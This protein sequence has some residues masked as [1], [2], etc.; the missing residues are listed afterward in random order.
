MASRRNFLRT[1]LAGTGA[2]LVGATKGAI[3]LSDGSNGQP[4]IMSTWDHGLPANK[5]AWEVLQGGGSVLD[6]VEQGVKVVESDFTNRSVGLGGLPDR[7]GSVTLDACIQDHEGMA[8]SV[9]FVQN[10]EN[11]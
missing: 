5:K 4:I 8:G 10:F 11:P 9:A 3:T 2:L 7:D 1:G 6:A